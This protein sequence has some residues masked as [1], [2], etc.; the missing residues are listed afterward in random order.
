MNKIRTL[1][2]I[3]AGASG[4]ASAP[5]AIAQSATNSPPAKTNEVSVFT[6]KR[7]EDVVR[8]QVFAKRETNSPLTAVDVATV[9]TINGNFKGITS[10]AGLEHCKA[11]AS[12]DLAGNQIT[13]LS[14]LKGL[15]QL[16]Y[17]NLASNKISNVST[18][19]TIGA[20]QYIEL[21][22]N[23]VTDIGSLSTCSNL[24]SIYLSNNKITSVAPLTNLPRVAT[25]YAD[26][27]KLKSI[28]GLQHLKWLTSVSLSRNQIADISPLAS[29]R[30][31]TWM[32]LEKNKIKDLTPL[33]QALTNDNAGPKNFAPFLN[34]YLSGN[35][36]NRASKKQL[37]LL[38]PVGTRVK[39]EK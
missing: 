12:I 32:L 18:L 35:P 23:Q 19:G 27:N 25:L 5:N 28:A 30:A 4:L 21:S 17:L 10:L 26:G 34:L 6:D 39:F 29:L 7:L 20:L 31:P 14:P 36:L 37:E 16:Q 38:K 24:A 3:L 2:L 15:K 33:Y 9:S 13:D 22:N 1:I 8:Q 11:I